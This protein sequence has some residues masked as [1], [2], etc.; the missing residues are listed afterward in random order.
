MILVCICCVMCLVCDCVVYMWYV[1]VWHMVCLSC[2]FVV[3]VCHV[4][5]LVYDIHVLCV[6]YDRCSVYSMWYVVLVCVSRWGVCFMCGM[7]CNV[8]CACCVVSMVLDVCVV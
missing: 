8:V 6:V 3:C 7:W 4:W 5:H 1:V 2:V